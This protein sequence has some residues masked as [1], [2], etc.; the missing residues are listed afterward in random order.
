M[1]SV[2]LHTL[3][4]LASLV[5]SITL[6]GLVSNIEQFKFCRNVKFSR[7]PNCRDLINFLFCCS[8][9]NSVGEA[10]V[11]AAEPDGVDDHVD[12]VE[13]LGRR[14]VQPE[15]APDAQHAAAEHAV[16]AVRDAAEDVLDLA[17]AFRG[18]G[19]G[20]PCPVQHVAERRRVAA[21]VDE[22][23]HAPGGDRLHDA[24]ARRGRALAAAA[25]AQAEP[26][27]AHE[28]AV[29]HPAGRRPYTTTRSSAL[30]PR[31]QRLPHGA[32]AATP[33]AK[34]ASTVRSEARGLRRRRAAQRPPAA[35]RR[36]WR[37]RSR[38]TCRR[39]T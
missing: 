6:A 39:R 28:L 5:R 11:E 1:Y 24:A 32:A 14:P 22:H 4:S 30:P 31:Q 2:L 12:H 26:R 21:V 16:A 34:N 25:R 19:D 10:E 8:F 35:A 13:P 38:P 9:C 37:G 17:D 18:D 23:R 7:V 33:A 20:E 27:P 15:V 36:P 29:V 3:V